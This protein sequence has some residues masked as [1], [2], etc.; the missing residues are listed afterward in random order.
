MKSSVSHAPWLSC[1]DLVPTERGVVFHMVWRMT[2][3]T[4]CWLHVLPQEHAPNCIPR[5]PSSAAPTS[6]KFPNADVVVRLVDALR[7]EHNDKW[8]SIAYMTLE[9]I[10][11][12]GN[13]PVISPRRAPR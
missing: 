11:P 1:I 4:T 7:L 12:V 5:T 2:P 6:S 3:S 10:A 8:P 13:D 9:T